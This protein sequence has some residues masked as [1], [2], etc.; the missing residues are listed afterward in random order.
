MHEVWT[1]KYL[2]NSQPTAEY[3]YCIHVKDKVHLVTVLFAQQRGSGN[4]PFSGPL[5]GD[6]RVNRGN[7]F[8]C[9]R[10]NLM[11]VIA[12][13]IGYG[14]LH[15]VIADEFDTVVCENFPTRRRRCRHYERPGRLA[16]SETARTLRMRTRYRVGGSVRP[17]LPPHHRTCGPASGG[18]LADLRWVVGVGTTRL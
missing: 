17:A 2:S 18:S 15:T 14:R 4:P 10:C 6:D 9:E 7:D 8:I 12:L 5:I 3:P 16:T 11:D 13:G 1:T